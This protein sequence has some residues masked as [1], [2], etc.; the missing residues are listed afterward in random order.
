[1]SAGTVDHRLRTP[2]FAAH[3]PQDD[4]SAA[5]TFKAAEIRYRNFDYLRFLLALEV[6]LQ[7]LYMGMGLPWQIWSTIPPV[8]A[9][10]AL[11]GFLIPQSLERSRNLWHFAWKRVL[12]TMPA[13]VV[14]L[15]GITIVFGFKQT[16][17]ATTQYLTAGYCGQFQGVTLPL[18]SL[19]VEDALYATIAFLFVFGA[20]RK[21]WVT[22]PIIA[23]L[24]ICARFVADG[25]TVYRLFDTSIAFF[26][27]NLL[28][29][30]HAQLRKISWFWPALGV[31]ASLM[32]W[33][34]FLGP[35]GAPFLIGSVMLLA[36]TLP[37]IK[38]RIPDLSYATYIWHGPIMLALIGPLAMARDKW[39]LMAT[40]AITTAG[41]A[42]VLVFDRETGPAAE[43]LALA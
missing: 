31:G 24:M 8:A 42:A 36:M 35:V 4:A 19:I 39:W 17:G 33:L 27:G 12:R 30:F 28:Y 14:L 38:L 13:L 21:V 6:V 23:A 18:W 37:Q 15:I 3:V 11:S 43:R 5:A 1:M 32:G 9:F 16:I 25:M 40:L 7:H 10:V 34:H 20:H 29:I 26:T 41:G 2:A 22:I